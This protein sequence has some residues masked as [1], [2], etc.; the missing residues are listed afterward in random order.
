MSANKHNKISILPNSEASELKRAELPSYTAELG[1]FPDRLQKA[2]GD[3]S[4]RSFAAECGMSDTVVRQYLSGKSEPTR[5]AIIAIARVAGCS[6][7]WLLTGEGPMK[8]G[9]AVEA[10]IERLKEERAD[11]S[12]V[13]AAAVS[14]IDGMSD[15][16]AA[17]VIKFLVPQQRRKLTASDIALQN[18]SPEG[19]AKIR[20]VL[21]AR[22]ETTDDERTK[23]WLEELIK[24]MD[25][26]SSN[27][28]IELRPTGT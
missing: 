22:I 14:Y 23:A 28:E 19:K 6:I 21:E 18:T 17:E 7:E 15:N 27:A 11:R 5:P 12:P 10:G 25:D 3:K 26:E 9:A 20:A 4:V 1:S 16:E 8:R 13:K 24:I 2:V